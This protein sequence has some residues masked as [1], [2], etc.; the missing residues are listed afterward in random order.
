[1]HQRDNFRYKDI[2][3]INQ[4]RVAKEIKYVGLYDLILQDVLK[5]AGKSKVSEDEIIEIIKQHPQILEDYKQLNVEY[6]VGNI[7]LRNI[8][9][10]KLDK[11]CKEMAQKVNKNLD[12]L[13]DIEKYTLEFEQ[14]PTLVFIFS[15]E[16]FLIFSVQY[17]IVLLNL[18]EYQLL[19]YA[20]FLSSVLVAW[21]Y[22]RRVKKRYKI[23]KKR[24]EQTYRETLKM[25][26]ELEKMGC[27]KKDDLWI[28][29]GDEHI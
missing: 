23:N 1:V 12:Y 2:G 17:F 20:L 15:I 4:Q 9:T 27:V 19:I 29:D 10:G 26:A 3:L 22:A 8:D 28:M 14:S 5:I 21:W 6:N 13:R 11:R 24:F 25:L 18:K 16:F 7:H